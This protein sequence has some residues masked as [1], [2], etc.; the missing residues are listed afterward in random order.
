ML[1]WKKYIISQM[2]SQH[3]DDEY[4]KGEDDD[5]DMMRILVTMM[6]LM[7]MMMIFSLY[8]IITFT[9]LVE[10]IF[11]SKCMYLYMYVCMHVLYRP[12]PDQHHSDGEFGTTILLRRA[13]LYGTNARNR[14]RRRR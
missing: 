7:M 9:Y 11:I 1:F 12:R 14:R 6:I 8:T 10:C 4:E 3:D 2:V 13:L 5:D